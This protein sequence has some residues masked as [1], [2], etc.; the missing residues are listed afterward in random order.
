MQEEKI[1]DK[2]EIK[3]STS[4]SEEFGSN[5]GEF[6]NDCNSPHKEPKSKEFDNQ[7][8]TKEM[9]SELH[10]MDYNSDTNLDS[11][12]K[13]TSSSTGDEESVEFVCLKEIKTNRK[14]IVKRAAVADLDS[15]SNFNN[16]EAC[17]N[18]EIVYT[19]VK[20][21]P[22]KPRRESKEGGRGLESK[23]KISTAA[24]NI[25]AP[26]LDV[27]KFSIGGIAA[28]LST[29]PMN[30][31]LSRGKMK[32]APPLTTNAWPVAVSINPDGEDSHQEVDKSEADFRMIENTASKENQVFKDEDK[33]F[34][35]DEYKAEDS[36]ISSSTVV[37][38]CSDS[39]TVHSDISNCSS[40]GHLALKKAVAIS[41]LP[42][43]SPHNSP[44]GQRKP[45]RSGG[46]MLNSIGIKCTKNDSSLTK[47]CVINDLPKNDDQFNLQEESLLF[48]QEEKCN[49]DQ[50]NAKKSHVS[51]QE[52]IFSTSE[53]QVTEDKNS[54]QKHEENMTKHSLQKH[55][56]SDI[57]DCYEDIE[58]QKYMK[59]FSE[60]NFQMTSHECF[61][62]TEKF[63]ENIENNVVSCAESKCQTLPD[64][65]ISGVDFTGVA[66]GTT[67]DLNEHTSHNIPK[68]N[69]PEHRAALN[70]SR[71]HQ[72]NPIFLN[73]MKTKLNADQHKPV[74]K[75]KITEHEEPL[76]AMV[77]KETL[78]EYERQCAVSIKTGNENLSVLEHLPLTP[79]DFM[80]ILQRKCI[81][82]APD[83]HEAMHEGPLSPLA[84]A[85]EPIYADVI[86]KSLVDYE[87]EKKNKTVSE[88]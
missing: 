83:I 64:C 10:N 11:Y 76:Y 59:P 1:L 84:V 82:V 21:V 34:I 88:S 12:K 44:L 49:H 16:D 3:I 32:Q 40:A 5:I 24:N 45:Y 17:D 35:I 46:E 29:V 61:E 33:S 48:L 20:S 58:F 74:F 85:S 14:S 63:S 15:V 4:S 87:N 9:N 6:C 37:E 86:E 72:T 53:F 36:A 68:T 7:E 79:I 70:A 39:M 2:I 27:D 81:E 57:V 18:Y 23:K 66:L 60:N 43:V 25:K 8:L 56:A 73:L 69:S 19:A 77:I 80:D 47:L 13:K 67:L 78:Q 55:V 42:W 54:L 38:S 52:D 26:D 28:K 22:T 75:R 41:P 65:G 62:E 51:K 50:T 71:L 31:S 30:G